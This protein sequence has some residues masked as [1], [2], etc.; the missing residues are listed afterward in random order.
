MDS[1]YSCDSNDQSFLNPSN[2][3]I[4][5]AFSKKS[6]S[7]QKHTR[8]LSQTSNPNPESNHKDLSNLAYGSSIRKEGS[9]E[10]SIVHELQ[11]LK[12]QNASL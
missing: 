11:L 5:Q 6:N 2:S 9:F 3:K 4:K 12:Q 1:T 10:S 8:H 7:H